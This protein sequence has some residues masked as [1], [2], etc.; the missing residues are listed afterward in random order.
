MENLSDS[1]ALLCIL[2][3][4]EALEYIIVKINIFSDSLR[5][6]ADGLLDNKTSTY[7]Y[8]VTS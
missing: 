6:R 4:V 3:V 2:R 5:R 8:A 1:S 7:L